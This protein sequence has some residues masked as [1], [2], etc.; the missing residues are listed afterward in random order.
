METLTNQIRMSIS[1]NKLLNPSVAMVKQIKSSA[2]LRAQQEVN[3]SMRKAVETI[4]TSNNN[5]GMMLKIDNNRAGCQIDS[6]KSQWD[7]ST[8]LKGNPLSLS[9]RVTDHNK[10]I[11]SRYPSK[12]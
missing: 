1:P 10:T 7:G 2:F 5:S 6:M 12:N 4:R 9:L 3:S 8:L 11:C